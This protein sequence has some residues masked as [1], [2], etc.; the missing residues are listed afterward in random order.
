M[1]K[2]NLIVLLVFLGSDFLYGQGLVSGKIV[3][4]Q[5][6]KEIPF[7]HVLFSGTPLGTTSNLYGNFNLEVPESVLANG[8]KVTCLGYQPYSFQL[9]ST[10]AQT[11]LIELQEDIIR[12]EEVV[13]KPETP[14][15]LM[16]Q[17]LQKIPDN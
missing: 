9:T 13:I 2:I 10:Q 6:S 15:N 4:S 16:K 8:F 7:A 12:L 14:E 1:N 5:T 3:D 11:L 17:A